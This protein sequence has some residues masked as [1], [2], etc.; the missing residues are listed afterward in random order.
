MYEIPEEPYHMMDTLIGAFRRKKLVVCHM[1]RQLTIDALTSHGYFKRV[2]PSDSDIAEFKANGSGKHLPSAF[3]Y[4]SLPDNDPSHYNF[5]EVT[6]AGRTAV[7]YHFKMLEQERAFE[8]K[9][10][11]LRQDL[12]NDITNRIKSIKV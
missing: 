5:Y 8:A 1:H 10:Q 3:K 9:L 2:N 12:A 7:H 11:Q 6:I 4:P